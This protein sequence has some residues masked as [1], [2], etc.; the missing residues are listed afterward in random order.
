MRTGSIKAI[1]V[2][3]IA[4]PICCGA[5]FPSNTWL[6]KIEFMPEVPEAFIILLFGLVLLTLATVMRVR[7]TR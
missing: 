4:M 1:I 5:V 6:A 3:L 7:V 2:L